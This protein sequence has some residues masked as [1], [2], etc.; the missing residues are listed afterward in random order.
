MTIRP[1]GRQ[2]LIERQ[3]GT[4]ELAGLAPRGVVKACGDEVVDTIYEEDTVIYNS[5]AVQ[6]ARYGDKHL[7]LLDFRDILAVV[8]E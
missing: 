8:E 1:L 4:P 5:L 7:L 6:V 2:V 3:P